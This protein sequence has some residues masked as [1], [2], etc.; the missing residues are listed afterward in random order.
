MSVRRC[1]KCKLAVRAIDPMC[2]VNV[3]ADNVVFVGAGFPLG[4]YDICWDCAKSVN[5]SLP[6]P[7]R[8]QAWNSC[9]VFTPSD[10]RVNKFLCTICR[11]YAREDDPIGEQ[12]TR[13]RLLPE[14]VL[15]GTGVILEGEA[16]SLYTAWRRGGMP[17]RALGNVLRR[18]CG[19]DF[20]VKFACRECWYKW[21]PVVLERWKRAGVVG[22]ETKLS[23]LGYEMV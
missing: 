16:K 8:P 17:D 7:P 22:Q 9:N 19:T 21:A 13:L 5:P 2:Q 10:D 12:R 15:R 6:P 18:L 20:G 3:C 1:P 23:Q 11:E 14:D 4:G